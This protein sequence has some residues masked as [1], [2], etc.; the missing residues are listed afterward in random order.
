MPLI[1]SGSSGMSGNVGTV[2]KEMLP[3]GAVLQVVQAQLSSVV[4]TT[5]STPTNTGL[6]ASITP[7]AANSKI[8]AILNLAT[9]HLNAGMN[10]AAR[11]SRNN[12]AALS[13]MMQDFYH[14]T[15]GGVT[16]NI[17]IAWL[18]SPNSTAP[19]VYE[20]LFGT[21]GAGG[22]LS[23]NKDYNSVNNGVS[24]ITLMEIKG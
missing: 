14:P 13:G 23:I 1:M 22:S 16:G 17:N 21:N 8:L 11:L 15:G 19:V 7:M 18:D 4:T 3:A 24:T 10:A 20:A 5:S 9:Y 12:G 6:I 2:T